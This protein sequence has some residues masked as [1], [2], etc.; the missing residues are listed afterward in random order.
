MQAE[1]SCSGLPMTREEVE[2]RERQR[3]LKRLRSAAA[4]RDRRSFRLT[5]SRDRPT[6]KPE[7]EVNRRLVEDR[8]TP[9][10]LVPK[11]RCMSLDVDR[12]CGRQKEPVN[13]ERCPPTTMAPASVRVGGGRST[14]SGRR[15][16]TTDAVTARRRPKR[17][18][19]F[20]IEHLLNGWRAVWF[21]Y[22]ATLCMARIM[23]SH[24]VSVCLSLSFNSLS[25]P[26]THLHLV[27]G[28]ST[29]SFW[30]PIT[31]FPSLFFPLPCQ[32]YRTFLVSS[33]LWGRI[34]NDSTWNWKGC[35]LVSKFII[36][37]QCKN[38]LQALRKRKYITAV[39]WTKPTCIE[40]TS[41]CLLSIPAILCL[42]AIF[43]M[44]LWLLVIFH[45]RFYIAQLVFAMLW[46]VVS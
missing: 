45:Y 14:S 41:F 8:H 17:F 31:P 43:V 38:F 19:E 23:L 25:V 40:E 29:P 4:N 3:Q 5:T 42:L 16:P 32:I 21:Y 20:T 27:A 39:C 26:L 36:Y 34:R 24:D 2:R 11:G 12:L 6:A 18:T 30:Q 10:R 46:G 9:E 33:P 7:P 44:L 22:R 37:F 13:E 1:R 35:C 28:L 15:Y